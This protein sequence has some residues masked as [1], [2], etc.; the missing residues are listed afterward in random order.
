[1]CRKKKN[2]HLLPKNYGYHFFFFI[3]HFL[4]LN[5]L[6]NNLLKEVF[7]IIEQ[8]TVAVGASFKDYYSALVEKQELPLTYEQGVIEVQ[9]H[10]FEG[11]KY[12]EREEWKVFQDVLHVAG[13]M[14]A[15]KKR[16][17]K[18]DYPSGMPSWEYE[19]Y[20]KSRVV[21]FPERVPRQVIRT[22]PIGPPGF[23]H[24]VAT[25]MFREEV[26]IREWIIGVENRLRESILK[27]AKEDRE[28]IEQVSILFGLEERGRNRCLM[29]EN[30]A[31]SAIRKQVFLAA[32]PDYFRKQ[33]IERYG[34]TVVDQREMTLEELE[35]EARNALVAEEQAAAEKIGEHVEFIYSAYMFMLNHAEINDRAEIEVEQRDSLY[36]VVAHSCRRSN[37]LIFYYLPSLSLHTSTHTP[38]LREMTQAVMAERASMERPQVYTGQPFPK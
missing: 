34:E 38:L 19:N 24:T 7:Y 9:R 3:C 10:E 30:E 13:I 6:Y 16:M 25:E 8:M 15:D 18:N 32:P 27:A 2:N 37:G 35:E 20:R 23:P 26:D 36:E 14:L 33:V 29:E 12:V 21:W 5:C 11:R 28:I 17:E 4:F 31:F 1:M 22:R